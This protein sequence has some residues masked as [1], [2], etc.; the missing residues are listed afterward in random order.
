ML[1]TKITKQQEIT[2]VE[3]NFD[4]HNKYH[5]WRSELRSPKFISTLN[6][7][8]R[9]SFVCFLYNIPNTIRSERMSISKTFFRIMKHTFF[10]LY[11]DLRSFTFIVPN[12]YK[13]VVFLVV[14]CALPILK[15]HEEQIFRFIIISMIIYISFT[16]IVSKYL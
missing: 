7:I 3:Y 4:F 5:K 14:F 10:E 8:T 15:Q 6:K 12:I 16:F 11:I 1:K 2:N 13:H 9:F